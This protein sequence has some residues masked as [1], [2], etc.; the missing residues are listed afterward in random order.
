MSELKI[1]GLK[2]SGELCLVRLHHS[3]TVMNRL[4]AFCAIMAGNR[5]NLP[6]VFSAPCSGDFQAACCVD[7]AHETL[8]KEMVDADPMLKARISYIPAVGLLTLF[9]H[10][11]SLKLFMLSLRALHRENFQV[12]EIGSSIG[13]LTY[14]LP[15]RQLD[16]AADVL[17]SVFKLDGNH[18]PFRTEMRI[19]Q[20]TQIRPGALE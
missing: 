10:Q 4:P 6:Y 13:A 5:I 14:V 16:A 7:A 12:M 1:R 8:I 2:L 9:P 11:S 3:P 20:G 17:K 15:Y 18:T 19:C